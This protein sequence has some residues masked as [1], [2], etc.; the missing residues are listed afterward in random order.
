MKKEWLFF[1]VVFAV[2]LCLTVSKPPFG[3]SF[4]FIASSNTVSASNNTCYGQPAADGFF[5]PRACMDQK[6]TKF[7]Y[8]QEHGCNAWKIKKNKATQAAKLSNNKDCS[9]WK[10]HG[11]FCNETPVL[12]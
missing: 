3:T 6:N 10:A 2:L 4:A 9:M 8:R 12:V 5:T 7:L 11:H 1:C